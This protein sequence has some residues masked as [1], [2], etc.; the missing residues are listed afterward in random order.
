MLTIM[1]DILLI[2]AFILVAIFGWVIGFTRTFF[3]VF[4]G[5]ASIFVATKYSHQKAIG[6]YFI[7]VLTAFLTIMLGWVVLKL[8]VFFHLKILDKIAGAVL[9]ISIV[10]LV[11]INAIIPAVTGPTYNA[12]FDRQTSAIY[13]AVSRIMQ[14]NILRFQNYIPQFL[15]SKIVRSKT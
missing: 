11:F 9:G 4:S 14:S 8:V 3:T 2:I 10:W 12:S 1:I 13:V 5:F 15:K 6:F 7:F